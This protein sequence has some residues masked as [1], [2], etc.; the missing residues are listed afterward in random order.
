MIDTT[1]LPHARGPLKV[2]DIFQALKDKGWHLEPGT[3]VAIKVDAG[4]ERVAGTYGSV[5]PFVVTAEE[6][7][8]TKFV[9]TRA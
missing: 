3:Y 1:R 9:A 4:T 7:V 2:D 8:S 5:L 6:V